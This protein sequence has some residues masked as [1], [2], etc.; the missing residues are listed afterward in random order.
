MHQVLQPGPFFRNQIQKRALR[1][2]RREHH[3]DESGLPVLMAMIMVQRHR[4]FHALGD[5]VAQI[6]G[7]K[8]VVVVV[9][10]AKPTAEPLGEDFGSRVEDVFRAGD[11]GIV[12]SD[13]R[14][15]QSVAS[16]ACVVEVGSI[17]ARDQ[18]W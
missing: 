12:R 18:Q 4:G 10:V 7:E 6:W 17:C 14:V 5:S 11:D 9:K 1:L 13:G 3:V 16:P 8:R 15:S 2:I